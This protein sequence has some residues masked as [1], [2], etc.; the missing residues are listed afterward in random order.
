MSKDPIFLQFWMPDDSTECVHCPIPIPI[1]LLYSNILHVSES[2]KCEYVISW[3]FSLRDIHPLNIF[4][5]WSF[6][7]VQSYELCVWLR[8]SIPTTYGA[9]Q[10]E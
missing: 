3:L 7:K 9:P 6:T 10:T 5:Y 1:L 4:P 2:G 8:V